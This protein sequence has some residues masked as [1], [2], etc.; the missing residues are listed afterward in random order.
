MKEGTG[1]RWSTMA[2]WFTR[3]LPWWFAAGKAPF[4]VVSREKDGVAVVTR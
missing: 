2:S 1:C 4:G 3:V